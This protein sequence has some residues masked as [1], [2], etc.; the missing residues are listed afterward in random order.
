MGAT[1]DP[2]EQNSQSPADAEAIEAAKLLQ[3]IGWDASNWKQAGVYANMPSA[4]KVA[5]MFSV[6][7]QYIGMLKKRLRQ[8][9]PGKSEIELAQLL[10]A[11]LDMAQDY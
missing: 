11:Y 5:L 1:G 2:S 4:R 6:R 10:R 7:H 3:R 9:H 8:E